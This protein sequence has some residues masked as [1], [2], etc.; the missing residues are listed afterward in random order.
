MLFKTVVVPFFLSVFRELSTKFGVSGIPALIII[1]P[2]G[3]VVV[4]N[5]RADVQ[6]KGPGAFKEWKTACGL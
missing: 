2:D 5:G 6:G 3:S 4:E 1:K